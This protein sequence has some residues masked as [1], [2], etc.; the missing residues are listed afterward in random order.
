MLEVRGLRRQGLEPVDLR[1]EDGG[2][3]SLE[4]P[5]GA[6]KTLLLRA[7]ADLDPSQGEVRLEGRLRED[8][9]GPDWR[10]QVAY[11]PAEP[12]WWSH[13]APDHFVDWPAGAAE[14]EALEYVYDSVEFGVTGLP[15]AAKRS[16]TH[17]F[18]KVK[19]TDAS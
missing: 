15:N 17:L 3:T 12:G 4:G 8:F 2:C 1:L 18:E 19:V 10:R 11:I 13:R 6:G 14:R 7:L 16:G 9:S 5:S